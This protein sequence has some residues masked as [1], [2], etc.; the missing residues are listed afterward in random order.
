MTGVELILAALAAGASA[1]TTDAVKTA[2]LDA[3][4]GLRDALRNRLTGW[5]RAQHVLDPVQSQPDV[6]QADL[7]PQLEQCGAVHDEEILAAA[8]RLLALAD[9]NGFA[10]GKYRIDASSAGHVH[11]GDTTI[12]APN[13]QGAVGT[14]NAPVT[15]GAPP[16]PPATPGA[17]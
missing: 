14:F 15:F 8:R 12:D 11:V 1:G 10:A 4:T 13:N 9:P 7:G 17:G 5:E 3:Y 16:L 2:V 6:W